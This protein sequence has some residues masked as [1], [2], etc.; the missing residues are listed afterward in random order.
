IWDFNDFHPLNAEKV[1]MD[2]SKMHWWLDGTHARKALGDVMLARI[3]GWPVEPEAADFGFQLTE[4][5][6]AERDQV[7]REGYERFKTEQAELWNWMVEGIQK[8]QH[9]AAKSSAK[10]EA[11]PGF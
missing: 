8:Y 4:A 3:M 10:D 6:A 1:P 9:T 11:A 5:N 2:S 7:L